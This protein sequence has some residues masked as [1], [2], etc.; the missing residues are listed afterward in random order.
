MVKP[1]P[2][3]TQ[4]LPDVQGN[5]DFSNNYKESLGFCGKNGLEWPLVGSQK[6][7]GLFHTQEVK[8]GTGK[9][10]KS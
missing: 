5:R 9:V 3:D 1:L 2:R 4:L 8:M 10:R 7:S 6:K